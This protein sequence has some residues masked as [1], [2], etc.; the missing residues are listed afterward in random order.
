M[1][2]T[3]ERVAV[4]DQDRRSSPDDRRR[5]SRSG[6][7]KGDRRWP[8]WRQS[9]AFAAICAVLRCWKWFKRTDRL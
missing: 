8:W 7:R 2:S 1:S 4:A 9:I 5:N 6:R 3:A